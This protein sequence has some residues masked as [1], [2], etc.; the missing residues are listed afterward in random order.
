MVAGTVQTSSP[1]C[2]NRLPPRQRRDSQPSRPSLA[3]GRGVSI[4][5]Q[6]PEGCITIVITKM[7]PILEIAGTIT[8]TTVCYV[9]FVAEREGFEPSMSFQPILP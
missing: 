9:N 6:A 4:A 8:R 1:S 2:S 7:I 5:R 3:K